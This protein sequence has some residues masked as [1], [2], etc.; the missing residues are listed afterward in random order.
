MKD[1][2]LEWVNFFVGVVFV[3]LIYF[4]R[5]NIFNVLAV[6]S[7]GAS[8]YGLISIIRAEKIGYAFCSFG[9]SIGVALI[10]YHFEVLTGGKALTVAL[11][12]GISLLM[13][14]TIIFTFVN[15]NTMLK[16][17]SL[18]VSAEV[19]DLVKNPNTNKEFYQPVYAYTIDGEVYSVGALNFINKNIPSIGERI[20]IYVDPKDHESVYFDKDKKTA[21]QDLVIIVVLMLVSFGIG[22]SM[23]F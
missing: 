20:T 15:R 9:I 2:I 18:P 19:I 11:M 8:I 1:K 16:K 6:A 12:F 23:F 10:F 5:N 7:I 14:V 21:I 17:F 22:I 4:F 3:L 13:L